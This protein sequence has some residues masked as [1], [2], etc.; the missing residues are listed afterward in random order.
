MCL[1]HACGNEPYLQKTDQTILMFIPRV[2]ECAGAYFIQFVNKNV[3]S[4]TS[5][6]EPINV[7]QTNQLILFIPRVWE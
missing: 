3:L 6:N 1:S 7:M 4:H 5:G 2:W